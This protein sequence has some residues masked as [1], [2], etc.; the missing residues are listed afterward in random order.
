MRADPRE[1]G[2][3]LLRR[4]KQLYICATRLLSDDVGERARWGNDMLC[5]NRHLSR[6]ASPTD[7]LAQFHDE[8]K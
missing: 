4:M 6:R 8:R 2:C 1:A 5:S 3:G 7:Q